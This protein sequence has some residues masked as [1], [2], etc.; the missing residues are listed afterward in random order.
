MSQEN[1][2]IVRRG[3]EPFNQQFKT[4]E[5]DLGSFARDVT[6]DNLAATFDGAVY[7]THGQRCLPRD[8][9]RDEE[10]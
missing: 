3:I 8:T 6:V 1:V 10:A 5:V 2:E 7:S 9:G 4:G